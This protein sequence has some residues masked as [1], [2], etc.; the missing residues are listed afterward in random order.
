MEGSQ[1]SWTLSYWNGA[2]STARIEGCIEAWLMPFVEFIFTKSPISYYS[3]LAMSY[4]GST[5]GSGFRRRFLCGLVVAASVSLCT[6]T[7]GR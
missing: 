7:K 5:S 3:V 6:C 1:P 2:T 4:A